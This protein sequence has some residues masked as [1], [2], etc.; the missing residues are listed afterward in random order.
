MNDSK[1]RLIGLAGTAGAGKDTVAEI[2]CRL[3]GA[4]NLSTGDFVRAVTRHIYRLPA[5]FNP[6]RDQ[7]YEVATYLRTE[8]NPATTVKMC[9]LQAKEL[10][11]MCA[12]IT[13]LRS[14]GEADAI[15]AQGG[16]IIGVDADPRVRYERISSRQRDSEAHKTFEQFLKQD[17]YENRGVSETGDGRGIRVIIENADVV[18]QN[19]NGPIEKLEGQVRE[20]LNSYFAN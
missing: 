14:M 10:H 15:R 11:V 16:I 4:E 12:L 19:E 5:D 9:I 18:I 6:V 7:L 3:Y 8:I 13:G 1:P 20:K 2:I 17:E